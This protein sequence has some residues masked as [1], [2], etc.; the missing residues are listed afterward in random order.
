MSNKGKC[1]MHLAPALAALVVAGLAT[2]AGA[3]DFK[4]GEDIDVTVR[5]NIVAG[6]N[7]RTELPNPSVYGQKSGPVV[8][9]PPGQLAGNSGYQ[10]LNF[11]D[12]GDPWSTVTKGLIDL[13][14]KYRNVGAF[15][16]AYAWYDFELENG[17]R[18]YGNYP[19]GFTQNVP[20]S[21][22]GFAR[23]AQ[24]SGAEFRDA[25]LFGNFG[26][27][28]GNN[29]DVRVGRQVV[30]WGVARDILGGINQVNGINRPAAE[31][32]GATLDETRVPVGMVYANFS[33]DAGWG[34]DGWYQY[35]FRPGVLPGCGTFLAQP[36]FSPPGCNY[37]SVLGATQTDP[38]SLASNQYVHRAPDVLASDSGQWGISGR[39]NWD[40]LATEIRL[41]AMNFHARGSFI[42][43]V[44][45][46]VPGQGGGYGTITGNLTRLTSPN[47]L[48][49]QMVYPED[50]KL[51]GVSLDSKPS[52]GLRVFGE[53]SY[54][55]DQPLQLNASDLI[56]A[57]YVRSPTSALNLAKGTNAIPPGGT[58]Q[59]WDR[60]GFSMTTVGA[61]QEWKSLAGA[62]RV[63]LTGEMGFAHV[64]DLP[65]PKSNL[66][67]G[68]SDDYG[69]AQVTGG[70]PCAG[71]EKTCSLQ[72]FVTSNAWGYRLRL[73]ADYPGALFGAKLIP[74][75]LYSKDVSGYSPQDVFLKDRWIVRPALRADWKQ[76]YAEIQ[77]WATGGGDYNTRVDRD[78][79][80][81]FAGMR[82]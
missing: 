70:A 77:Y 28:E 17:D 7:I 63:V 13:R 81:I 3:V 56:N 76:Y 34:V 50:I 51:F 40:A 48:K 58:F 29:L 11:K 35:E 8:G 38:Q 18:P 6:T 78:Y 82:F 26:L 45:G 46:N 69:Q 12:A 52:E 73:S 36:N 43:V 42:Q 16:R 2:P 33:S 41:Y 25:Y 20:L 79:V 57:F 59:G 30:R 31:R 4:L 55:P 44:N 23:Q 74:S 80:S 5:G 66:R 37:V 67:Y 75:L 14:V 49:Y 32:P 39:Y 47:G 68:R 72:G 24:F 54:R 27:G 15:L 22:N 21:D 61:T 9:L 19:N 64:Y 53:F 71:G 65:D 1:G 62:E 10:N 60:Y